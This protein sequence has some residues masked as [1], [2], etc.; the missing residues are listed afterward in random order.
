M[1]EEEN[2]IDEIKKK[3][4]KGRIAILITNI[5]AAL[6]FASLYYLFPPKQIIFLIL[7]IIMFATAIAA[8]IV[9]KRFEKKIDEIQ[10]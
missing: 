4:K 9:F 10:K 3:L 7:A 1:K 6:A 5:L 8:M 2:N